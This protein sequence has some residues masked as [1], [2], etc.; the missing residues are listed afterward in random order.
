MPLLS[1]AVLPDSNEVEIVRMGA[2]SVLHGHLRSPSLECQ[3]QAA[4]TIANLTVNGDISA[5]LEFLTELNAHPLTLVL[6]A[7]NKVRAKEENLESLLENCVA[8][9]DS[10]VQRQA[11]RALTNI[12]G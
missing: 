1:L 2:F 3:R 12:R 10:V 9:P 8:S 6:A 5:N 11:S 4:R 7:E